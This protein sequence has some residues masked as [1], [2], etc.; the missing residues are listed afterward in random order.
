MVV[1]D[2][3]ARSKRIT[4]RRVRM[5]EEE[6]RLDREFWD[7]LSPAERLEQTW[8]LSLELW[9][10]KGWDPGEPGLYRTVARVIRS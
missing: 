5:G 1:S 4:L 9:R 8:E 6:E 10:F 2:A 7:Q 3:A